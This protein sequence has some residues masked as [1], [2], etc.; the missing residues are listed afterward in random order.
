MLTL[1]VGTIAAYVPADGTT[2]V[3]IQEPVEAS[4]PYQT[5]QEVVNDLD[6]DFEALQLSLTL[7]LMEEGE[8][9]V[10]FRKKINAFADLYVKKIIYRR[11]RDGL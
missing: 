10:I 3:T 6:Q 9:H 4:N 8:E 2:T 11:P 5:L 7:N 1:I